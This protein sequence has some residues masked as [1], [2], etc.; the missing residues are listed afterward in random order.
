MAQIV[1]LFSIDNARLCGKIVKYILNSSIIFM[2]YKLLLG[3]VKN[4]AD[5]RVVTTISQVNI[6]GA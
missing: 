5:G 6:N 3:V 4:S 2:N 1:D